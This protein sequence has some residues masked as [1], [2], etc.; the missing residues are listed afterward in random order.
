MKD[1]RY[2]VRAEIPGLDP[3]KTSK[4]RSGTVC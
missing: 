2:E 4:S 3:A 1:G